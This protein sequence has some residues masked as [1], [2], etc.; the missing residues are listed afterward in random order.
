MKFTAW[1]ESINREGKGMSG[2]NEGSEEKNR[3]RKGEEKSKK[4]V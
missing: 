2:I 1:N 4:K 3:E